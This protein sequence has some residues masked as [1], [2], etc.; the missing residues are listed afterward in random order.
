MSYFFKW[1]DSPVG[2]LKLGATDDGLAAILWEDDDPKR[3]RLAL[4]RESPEHPVLLET[5]RQLGEYFAGRRRAFTLRLDPVGTP[6]QRKVWQALA[7]IPFGEVRS[8]GELAR[9]IGHPGASR[10]VGTAN[11]RNPL[12]IVVPCHRVIGASG[13]L[14]GFAGG[15][16]NKAALLTLEGGWKEKIGID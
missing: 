2:R 15:L 11:G 12:S 8:Y 5:E 7:E 6:F 10:A 14:T 13:R 16:E 3:V 4:L 1:I 9:Q